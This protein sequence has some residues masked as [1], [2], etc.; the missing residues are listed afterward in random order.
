MKKRIRMR[1]LDLLLILLIGLPFVVSSLASG[2]TTVDVTV[3]LPPAPDPNPV[4]AIVHHESSPDAAEVATMVQEAVTAVLGPSELAA[5]VAPGD[6]V[7]IKPNLGVGHATHQTTDWTVVAP[8]AEMAWAAG[9]S[10]VVITEGQGPDFAGAGYLDNMP[11]DTE[12]VDLSA[13]SDFYD[14]TVE[15]G[16]WSEPI[17]IPQLYFDADVVITVPAFKTHNNAGVTIGV[18]NAMGV[19]PVTPYSSGGPI[20]WRDLLHDEYGIHGAIPQINLARQPD[21]VVVDGLEG[22]E[23]EGPWACSS[24]QM[25][26]ILA[27]QDAVALDTVGTEI[28]GCELCEPRRIAHQVYAAYKNLGVNDL[29]AIQVVGTPIEQV[30]QVFASPANP[31][32]IYRATT[33]IEATGWPLTVD[34]DLGDWGGVRPIAL[35]DEAMVQIGGGQWT[36]PDDLSATARALY[37]SEALYVA[38]AV[39]DDVRQVNTAS[40]VWDGDGMELYI[41]SRDPWDVAFSHLS[42]G[43]EFWLGVI[44]G[45]SPTVW[46]IGRDQAVPGA[47]VALA[48]TADGYIVELRIPWAALSGFQAL[49]NRQ[50]GFD[51][52]MNDD[53]TGDGRETWLSWGGTEAPPGNSAQWG[54]ARLG[55]RHGPIQLWLPVIYKSFARLS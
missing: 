21:L 49:E 44:Y 27:A 7:V 45:P 37:D 18:K 32:E 28:M 51:L 20:T 24:V 29:V 48:D 41:N 12:F 16:Y 54:V 39:R 47:E 38:V 13:V 26:L 8:L 46:D 34:G 19:P 4:V 33:V 5:L 55:A 43:D 50:I 10:R 11:P 6:T 30:Q 1:P 53:D 42:G 35:E 15:G 2:A 3:S 40:P 9:A 14:V 22:C 36:G 52:G 25:N 31:E 17:I 23:G